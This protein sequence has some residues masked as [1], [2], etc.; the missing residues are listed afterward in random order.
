MINTA[1]QDVAKMMGDTPIITNKD[2]KDC[3][4]GDFYFF[5]Q[6]AKDP[7]NLHVFRRAVHEMKLGFLIIL[8]ASGFFV[9]SAG[10]KGFEELLPWLWLQSWNSHKI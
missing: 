5:L 7:K 6:I 9:F 1:M 8:V 10:I 2:K 4:S 3:N